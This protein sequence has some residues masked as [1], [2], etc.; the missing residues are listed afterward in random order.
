MD[1][2]NMRVSIIDKIDEVIDNLNISEFFKSNLHE[3]FTSGGIMQ[4]LMTSFGSAFVLTIVLTLFSKSHKFSIIRLP[5]RFIGC[6]IS[7]MIGHALIQ[8]ITGVP[9]EYFH[10]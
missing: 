7:V 4:W 9:L 5:L 6:F 3:L 2:E 1:G 10:F 8:M